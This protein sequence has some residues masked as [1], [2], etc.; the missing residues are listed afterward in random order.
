MVTGEN[1]KGLQAHF[2]TFDL[3]V[4]S[5]VKYYFISLHTLKL[6]ITYGSAG[7]L[8]PWAPETPEMYGAELLPRQDTSPALS[9]FNPYTGIP[10]MT[11]AATNHSSNWKWLTVCQLFALWTSVW[12][13]PTNLS[14]SFFTESNRDFILKM[15]FQGY[16]G[17]AWTTP[18]GTAAQDSLSYPKWI[19]NSNIPFEEHFQKSWHLQKI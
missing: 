19:T 18:P 8:P 2:K 17:L 6:F 11:L 13:T 16:K 1:S 7:G 10:F 12:M 14:L 4:N 3:L 15:V 5:I 9:I